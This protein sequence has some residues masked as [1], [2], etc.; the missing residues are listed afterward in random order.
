MT[1]HLTLSYISEDEE[2]DD[3]H[4]APSS[5]DDAPRGSHPSQI[6]SGNKSDMPSRPSG[7]VVGIIK[8]NW[9]S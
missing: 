3:V 7:R 5:A 2:D 8:R 9:H 6:S 4:L 1:F